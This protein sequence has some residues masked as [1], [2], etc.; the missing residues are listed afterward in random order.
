MRRI[1][2]VLFDLDETLLD[3]SASLRSFLPDQY[4]RFRGQLGSAAPEVWCDRFIALDVRGSVPKTSVYPRLLADFGGDVAAAAALLAD[5]RER[6]CR[7][8]RAFPNI[9]E[10]LTALRRDGRRTG[11]ITNGETEFQS[12]SIEALGLREMLD[13]ILISAAEGLRK[14]DAALF[15]RAAERLGVTPEQ[16]LF[17]GDNPVADVLG[18]Q[19]AGMSTAWFA[20]GQV[21]PGE[22]PGPPGAIIRELPEVLT[23]IDSI[24]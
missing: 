5:Y 21:W 12:R 13:V 4:H 19:A 8:A 23:V 16:C 18:A 22:L 15:L 3:R 10:T 11:L 2:A 14:P 24:G 1:T 20:N 6:F 17:V 9:R 7:H